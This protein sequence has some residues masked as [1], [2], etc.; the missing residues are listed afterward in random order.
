M[1]TIS[2]W[3]CAAWHQANRV[4][5]LWVPISTTVFGWRSRTRVIRGSSS[6]TFWNAS[7]RTASMASSLSVIRGLLE[8]AGR[9]LEP[10]PHRR[11]AARVLAAVELAADLRDQPVALG[12]HVVS[13]DRLQVLLAGVDEGAVAELGEGLAHPA[14]H[15]ADAVLDEAG[16]GV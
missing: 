6:A 12:D 1:L 3:G 16:V 10:L 4:P 2:A 7:R 8:L 13:V 15:L 5:P 14:D 9:L 11:V